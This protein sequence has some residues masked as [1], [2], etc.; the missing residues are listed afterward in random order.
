MNGVAVFKDNIQ[1]EV[2]LSDKGCGVRVTSL[3]TK[4][5]KGL[6]GFHIHKAGDLRGESS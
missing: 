3:F 4:L 2:V 1:G 5:P 6:H